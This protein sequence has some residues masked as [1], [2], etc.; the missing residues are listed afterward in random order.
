MRR[1]AAL[2][3]CIFLFAVPAH[4]ANAA[5][6]VRTTAVV[7][8]NSACQ[9]TIEAE[10]RLDEPARGLKFPLG[11]DIHSVTLNGAAASVTQSGGI[12]SVS[13]SH[14]NG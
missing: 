7:T 3:I 8:E 9:V 6:S 2:L 13:L 5:A 14:L 12:T 4:A 11:T 1:L 10:I